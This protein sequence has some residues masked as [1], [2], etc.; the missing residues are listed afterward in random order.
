MR[1]MIVVPLAGALLTATIPAPAATKQTT[2]GVSANVAANCII[3]AEPLSFGSYDA[4]AA[5]AGSADLTVRCSNGTPYTVKLGP[6][7][8]GTFAQRLL[9]SGSN[10]LEYNLYTS[11]TLSSVWGDGTSNTGTGGGTGAGLA[12]G[13]AITHTVYGE[14]PN[15]DNNQNAP[16]GNYS[17]TVT[18]TVEY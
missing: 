11:S 3:N 14:L 2:M 8:T 10:S 18:V 9:T 12:A 15:T 17:D 7:A 5:K 4:G 6:G 16:A 1:S 13:S